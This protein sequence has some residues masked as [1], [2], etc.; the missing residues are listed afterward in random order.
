[1]LSQQNK[2]YILGQFGFCIYD[3][4]FHV[5]NNVVSFDINDGGIY[6]ADAVGDLYFYSFQ[7]D[8]LKNQRVNIS[9]KIRYVQC[10]MDFTIVAST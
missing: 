9:Q 1:M 3:E 4:P 10:G 2:L 6:V 7:R 5:N 8:N